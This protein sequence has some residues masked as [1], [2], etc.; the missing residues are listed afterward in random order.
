MEE[1]TVLDDQGARTWSPVGLHP[2]DRLW[3]LAQKPIRTKGG[4]VRISNSTT[5]PAA[6]T[7]AAA[8]VEVEPGGVRELHW[9][10]NANEAQY[11]ISGQTRMTVLA[12]DSTAGTFDYQPGDVGFLPRNMGHYIE[13][14]GTTKLQFLELWK[15]DKFA[16][17]SLR[18]KGSRGS[19]VG[20]VDRLARA[21]AL[22]N[23]KKNRP[24]ESIPEPWRQGAVRCRR[25]DAAPYSTMRRAV[26]RNSSA[27]ASSSQ[28]RLRVFPA[29]ESGNRLHAVNALHR[30]PAWQSQRGSNL[31]SCAASVR[32]A[33]VL[34]SQSGPRSGLRYDQALRPPRTQEHGGSFP[35]SC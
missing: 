35:G 7:I 9:H 22:R 26:H 20:N 16:D 15:T 10:P 31:F 8:Y 2:P 21:A 18:Q 33:P 11:D 19:P 14:T 13:N 24:G 17:V 30:N 4:T 23:N 29:I 27:P 34:D 3:L 1:G 5:F 6:T 28:G 32:P 12:T 25:C